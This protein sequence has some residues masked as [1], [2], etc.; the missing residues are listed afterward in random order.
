M[1]V[2]FLCLSAALNYGDRTALSA[3]YPLLRT[4]LRMSD[5]QLGALGS[6]FLWAYALSSPFAGIL[7]DRVSRRKTVAF[8][9]GGWSLATVAAGFARNADE[10]LLTRA[11][12]GIAESAYLP[13]AVALISAYHS[14][15]S[16]ARAIGVH[17]SALT[18]GLVLSTV[19]AA[20]ARRAEAHARQAEDAVR[21]N[22]YI[23][24]MNVA[25]QEQGTGDL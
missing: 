14:P 11:A 18:A 1:L 12:L 4:E 8:S 5:L 9:L 15:E 13:S 20:R 2:C 24:D 21:Q 19:Q 3:L 25:Q 7:A 16:R 23:S 17:V 6:T 10:L 22:L